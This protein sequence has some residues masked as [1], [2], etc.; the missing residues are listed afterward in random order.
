MSSPKR[1]F[2]VEDQAIVAA[3]LADRLQ[4]M[5]YQVAGSTASGE[6]AV[7]KIGVI[8]PDLVLMDIVLTGPMDGI[9]AAD[10]I[11]RHDQI[12]VVFLTAHADAATTGRAQATGPF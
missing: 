6:E 12:P 11:T 8:R 9:M 2:I 3:D 4:Q 1:I 7:E 5:G 10:L